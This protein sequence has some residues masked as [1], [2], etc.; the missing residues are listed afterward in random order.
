MNAADQLF[1]RLLREGRKISYIRA[2]EI[3]LGNRPSP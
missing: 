2:Y 1:E 3:L